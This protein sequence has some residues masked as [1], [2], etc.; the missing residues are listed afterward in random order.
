MKSTKTL[1]IAMLLGESSA[2][3]S[4]SQSQAQAGTTEQA[5][6]MIEKQLSAR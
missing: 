2:L 4:N 5:I 1:A 3:N 6:S